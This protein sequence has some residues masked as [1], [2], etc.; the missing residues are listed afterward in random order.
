M[1][2]VQEWRDKYGKP[3]VN[4]ELEYEGNIPY[5]WGNITAE[6]EVHRF[7]IMT[8]NGGYAGHGETYMHPEDILWWGKGGVLYGD[9]WKGIAFLREIMEDAP[10]G[11]LTPIGD[12][13]D[14]GL[15]P[16]R[17]TRWYW[18]RISGGMN[19]NYYLIYLGEH[20]IE[21]F[22]FWSE[23]DNYDIEILDTRAHTITPIAMKAFDEETMEKHTYDMGALPTYYLELPTQPYL[24]IRIRRK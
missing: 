15:F 10:D 4:D 18:T 19:G 21:N 22:Y 6:E 8:V 3:I 5:V 16:N 11:G 1:K 24:A 9:S 17:F 13:E 7:W 2:R 12:I 14:N 20:Q 23:D